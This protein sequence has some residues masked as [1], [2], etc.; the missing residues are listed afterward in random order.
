VKGYLVEGATILAGRPKIGKSWLALDWSVAVARG[1]F[2]FGDVHCKEGDVLYIALEDNKRRLK[3][4]LARILGLIGEWP[5]KLEY[6]TEL[7]RAKEGGLDSIRA[8]I[9]SKETPRLVVVDVL[10]TFRSRTR[11]NDNYY[12]SD[13]ET[14][15]AL[16][17]IASE[18]SIAILIIHH[19]RKGAADN[20]PID[21]ISGTL[22]LSGG[23]DS[24]LILDRDSNGATL[25]GRGRD[26]EGIERAVRFSRETCRWDVLGEAAD[27]RR[28]SE[29]ASILEVLRA[30]AEALTPLKIAQ[31]AEM[32]RPNVRQM[33]KK[34]VEDGEV[35]KGHRSHYAHPDNAR[36]LDDKKPRIPK[37]PSQ[38]SQD[39]NRNPRGSQKRGQGSQDYNRSHDKSS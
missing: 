4:R 15:K 32:P 36:F 34:M 6:A 1:G 33:L 14:T 13:Y 2:C 27:V 9:R 37:G 39:H 23:S 3:S 7:P 8:W 28:S 12:T 20:D 31:E 19:V 24:L 5:E 29:R 18:T 25:Y 17:A 38:R 22:G 10:E 35:L 16:Q 21:K 11:G 26:I 30:A